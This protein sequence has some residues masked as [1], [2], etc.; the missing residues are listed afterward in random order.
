MFGV[1]ASRAS[2]VGHRTERPLH[3]VAGGSPVL[4]GNPIL[5]FTAALFP[6]LHSGYSR[7]M[8]SF[9]WK[10]DITPTPK[11]PWVSECRTFWT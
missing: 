5:W 10:A 6:S 8:R 11:F 1:D 3:L 4:M 9:L 2:L 7:F